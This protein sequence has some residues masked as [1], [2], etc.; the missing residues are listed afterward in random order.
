MDT[1][2]GLG[3][4]QSSKAAL[5]RG[6]GVGL[7]YRIIDHDIDPAVAK[8]DWYFPLGEVFDM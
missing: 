6:G 1:T 7:T 3:A 5:A 4:M 8:W 2:F